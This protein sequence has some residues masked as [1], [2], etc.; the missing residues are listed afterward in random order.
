MYLLILA[1]N[2]FGYILGGFFSNSSGHPAPRFSY[3]PP[4]YCALFVDIQIPHEILLAIK[5]W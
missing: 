2:E 1:K 4:Q 5:G 3:L